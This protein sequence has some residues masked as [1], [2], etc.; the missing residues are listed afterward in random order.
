M[1]AEICAARLIAPFFGSSLYVWSAVMAI[2]LA[3]LAAGYFGGGRLSRR[4][5]R[6]KVLQVVV[7]LAL[8][9]LVL[10]PFVAALFYPIAS[11]PLLP[12]V[13]LGVFL[14]LFPVMFLMGATSPL[15]IACLT[16]RAEQSGENS[17]KIYAISTC[18][19]ILATFACG[20]WLIPGFGLM[21]T[22]LCF[23]ALLL[24]ALLVYSLELKRWKQLT[25]LVLP[26]GLMA[27]GFTHARRPVFT[28]YETDGIFGKIE[29][30]EQPAADGKHSVRRLL[31]NSIV[32]TEMEVESGRPVSEYAGLLEANLQS[33]PPGKALVLG[34]GGG[35]VAG[36]LQQHHYNVTAVEFDPRIV[37]LAQ[38][39]FGLS[40]E[41][42]TVTDDA[43]HFIN[44]ATGTYNLVLFD[45]FK[46]EEQPSHV[47]T[48]QGLE[49][50]KLHLAPGAM[51]IINT[52]GYLEGDKGAGTR[53]IL[54]TLSSAGFHCRVCATGPEAD[55]RNLLI[56]ASLQQE[57]ATLS[58]QLSSIPEPN[59]PV[60]TD[61][62]P[63]LES[64]NAEAN[65]A[66]RSNYIRNY[67]LYR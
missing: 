24:L 11:L 35:V 51:V 67:I 53:C 18:G 50:L 49:A 26:L 56:Y 44:Q 46:A 2:T 54:Q 36:M 21:A 43:R 39:Y 1:A 45:I 30:T 38:Q 40:P 31:V 61:Q 42:K 62:R 64:L 4:P 52:H 14:L 55:Y 23:A 9:S 58:G 29:I 48:T 28:V 5:S 34:L 10:M 3:G 41:V 59:G 20:F 6:A 37:Q 57:E 13:V 27:Y 8:C 17:G 66:W 63:V 22:L 7:T 16:E 19:G 65:Q 12:A 32:Q 15:I 60:N 33:T 47:I 25:V